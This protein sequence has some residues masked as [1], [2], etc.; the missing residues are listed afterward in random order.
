MNPQGSETET[1]GEEI[2]FW[3]SN[4]KYEKINCT[5]SSFSKIVK[6]SFSS[7]RD[8]QKKNLFVKK[9]KA[10]RFNLPR[11]FWTEETIENV[12]K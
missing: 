3:H 4:L 8:K 5:S 12:L 10:Q 1:Q 11:P 9:F 2:E 7:K 6:F